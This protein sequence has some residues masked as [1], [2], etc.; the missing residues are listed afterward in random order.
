VAYHVGIN[1]R[2]DDIDI[3]FSS[4]ARHVVAIEHGW[5][6]IIASAKLYLYEFD[7]INFHLQD[8]TA[9]YYISHHTE[10]PIDIIEIRDL[11]GA[12]FERDVEVR[13]LNRLWDL[14]DK[15]LVSSLNWSFCRMG[16]AR[17]R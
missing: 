5:F 16:N 10:R 14:R 11:F 3:F 9:G 7:P 1:T 13:I 4:G 6:S 2:A 17:P 12:L 15:V 8:D